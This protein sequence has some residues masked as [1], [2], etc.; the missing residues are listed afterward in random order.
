[1]RQVRVQRALP[2]SGWGH[3][4]GFSSAQPVKSV[5]PPS[6]PGWNSSVRIVIDWRGPRLA[7]EASG[8]ARADFAWLTGRPGNRR[9]LTGR[10]GILDL[11]LMLRMLAAIRRGVGWCDHGNHH[12]RSRVY[13]QC[14]KPYRKLAH[15]PL[16]LN[17]VRRPTG[18]TPRRNKHSRA[19]RP[20]CNSLQILERTVA[21][22]RPELYSAAAV[23]LAPAP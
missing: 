1:M 3:V 11:L 5:Q 12:Q 8:H 13:G 4:G 2:A 16:P 19:I 7:L 9:C 17:P 6:E 23:G 20:V 15:A 14:Q 10:P 21:R 18:G 22:A